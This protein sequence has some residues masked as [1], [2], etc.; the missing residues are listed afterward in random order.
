MNE[1]HKRAMSSGT[2]LLLAIFAGLFLLTT[3]TVAATVT[4]VYHSGTISLEVRPEDDSQI[5]FAL[6]A[7]VAN[8][9]IAFVPAEVIS[10][11]TDELEPVWPTVEAASRAL[12]EAPDF[13]LL[14]IESRD[15]HVMVRK[16][17][18]RLLVSVDDKGDSV[19]V[20][21]PLSTVRRIVDKL[22]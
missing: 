21:L 18:D 16:Q 3:V 4:A 8:L 9:A 1:S 13:T 11:L 15:T 2:R 19:S 5:S 14:E 12:D 22:S 6:P 10:D 17:G 7:A 20:A